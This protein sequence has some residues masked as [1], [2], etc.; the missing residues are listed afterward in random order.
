[1]THVRVLGGA[2]GAVL[3][4]LALWHAAGP[5]T[6]AAHKT[7]LS[8]YGYNADVFPILRDKCGACHVKGGPGPMSLLSYQEAFPWAQ[9]IKEEVLALRM[10]PLSNVI[11]ADHF[12]N[13]PA[14]SA[15]EMDVLVDWANGATPEGEEARKP[16]TPELS[17][18]WTLGKPDLELTA[19]RDVTLAGGEMSATDE[20]TLPTASTSD[21]WL[22]AVDVQSTAPAMVR[23]VSVWL[24][25]APETP[26]LFWMPG[27]R[28]H[29]MDT[30]GVRLP[31]RADLIVRVTYKKTW[32]YESQTLKDR[33]TV[34]LYFHAKPPAS[35]VETLESRVAPDAGLV[36]DRDRTLTAI[37]PQ[38]SGPA[39]VA[40]IDVVAE[41][42]GGQRQSLVTL[43]EPQRDW[44]V[45]FYFDRPV[46]LSKGSRLVTTVR[47]A[48]AA[49]AVRVWVDTIAAS[50]DARPTG[51][52]P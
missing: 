38:V 26:L 18:G 50:P 15:R 1:M 11:P 47:P 27:E 10:P 34:A 35:A 17:R 30:Q 19:P 9:A 48:D 25:A 12:S 8:K 52:Q 45:R 20:F 42:P 16:A 23:A 29:V 2:S 51:Q 36:F 40:S 49:P 33:T 22:R 13:V 41:L 4:V 28:P 39:A 14:L 32:S 43:T 44:P 24:K 5:S 46:A 21:R 3:G 7:I 31:A 6:L 37:A